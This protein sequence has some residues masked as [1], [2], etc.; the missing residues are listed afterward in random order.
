V[1]DEAELLQALKVHGGVAASWPIWIAHR[2]G[3]GASFGENA[4]RRAMRQRGFMD[5]KSAAVSAEFSAT[6]YARK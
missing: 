2:K 6:R 5:N 1:R 3:S 4:V